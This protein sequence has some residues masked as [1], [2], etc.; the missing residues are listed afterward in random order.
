[1]II[2][3]LQYFFSLFFLVPLLPYGLEHKDTAVQKSSICG[4]KISFS[5]GI[6]LFDKMHKELYVSYF[7]TSVIM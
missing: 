7:E 6:P 3:P 4:E 1:M 2:A 5:P